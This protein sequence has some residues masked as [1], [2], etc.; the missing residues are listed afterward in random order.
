MLSQFLTDCSSAIASSDARWL[1]SLI[2][3]YVDPSYLAQI[4]SELQSLGPDRV[5]KMVEKQ[6][7]TN[8]QRLI[9]AYVN[10]LQA[11]EDQLHRSFGS[12]LT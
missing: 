11:P 10:Y 8:F 6:I 5:S 3:G 7:P 9:S 2:N 1:S 12:V 4:C